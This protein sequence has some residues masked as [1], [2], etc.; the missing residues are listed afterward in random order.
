MRTSIQLDSTTV[1]KLKLLKKWNESYDDVLSRLLPGDEFISTIDSLRDR[2]NRDAETRKRA[3]ANDLLKK[4]I[5][6]AEADNK[7]Y[8]KFLGIG[9]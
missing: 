7:E 6:R 9:G 3:H 4:E 8:K 5:A 2:M 1:E